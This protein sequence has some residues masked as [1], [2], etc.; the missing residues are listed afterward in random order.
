MLISQVSKAIDSDGRWWFSN[1]LFRSIDKYGPSFSLQ[2]T[3]ECYRNQV[4]LQN[5]SE[6]VDRQILHALNDIMGITV[7]LTQLKEE[8]EVGIGRHSAK[9]AMEKFINELQPYYCSLGL[10][11]D[12]YE[13]KDNVHQ[14]VIRQF[15]DSLIKKS[16]LFGCANMIL[17]NKCE[18][19]FDDEDFD[20]QIIPDGALYEDIIE[21]E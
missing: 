10:G 9:L 16:S 20:S 13:F 17:S 18:L 1:G 11:G 21:E 19:R 2:N 12:D 14:I 7:A 5:D 3:E 4:Y 8:Y 15:L 6:D